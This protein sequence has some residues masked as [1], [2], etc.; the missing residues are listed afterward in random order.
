MTMGESKHEDKLWVC[1]LPKGLKVW[2]KKRAKVLGYNSASAY[3]RKW[4]VD[5]KRK[6]ESGEDNE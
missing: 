2:F 5:K 3:V 6:V 1:G 4:M